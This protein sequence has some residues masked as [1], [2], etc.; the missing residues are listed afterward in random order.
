M[1]PR[2]FVGP[3]LIIFNQPDG[4]PREYKD[5]KRVYRI[6]SSGVLR[7]QFPTPP[8]GV[9]PAH[10]HYALNDSLVAELRELIGSEAASAD[11]GLYVFEGEIGGVSR[12]PPD[13]HLD[14]LSYVVGHVADRDSLARQARR[15]LD[16]ETRDRKNPE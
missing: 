5:G 4:E 16:R 1:L 15:L 13:P 11:T 3:V 12:S 7:T 14:Y 10:F 8:S 2:G 9:V 6:P